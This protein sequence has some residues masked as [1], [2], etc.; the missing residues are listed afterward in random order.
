MK[1]IFNIGNIAN[2]LNIP[3]I[4]VD[5]P[6]GVKMTQPAWNKLNYQLVVKEVRDFAVGGGDVEFV[7]HEKGWFVSGIA[8]EFKKG[9]CNLYSNIRGTVTP[10]CAF[11]TGIPPANQGV[12]Y[13]ISEK[14]GNVY[15]SAAMNYDPGPVVLTTGTVVPEVVGGKELFIA[16]K[17]HGLMAV[18]IAL[19][20]ADKFERV[21]VRYEPENYICVIS[22]N[23][24]D[25]GT[26]VE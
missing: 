9:G 14:E 22:A 7:G 10:L 21:F 2:K 1:R 23:D 8:Y 11:K 5:G 3:L 12:V 6:G 15:I 25:I 19:A 13:E 26:V 17:G 16:Y 18:G 4:E 24:N 20:Y